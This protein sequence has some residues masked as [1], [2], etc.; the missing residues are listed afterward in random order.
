MWS[1]LIYSLKVH[2]MVTLFYVKTSKKLSSDLEDG[3]GTKC[4]LSNYGDQELTLETSA[5]ASVCD[6]NVWKK[7]W[8]HLGFFWLHV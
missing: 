7:K 3:S 6:P 2:M 4:S 1:L 8:E 5:A